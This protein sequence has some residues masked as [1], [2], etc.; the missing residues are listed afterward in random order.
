MGG[1][2][3]P[4]PILMNKAKEQEMFDISAKSTIKTNTKIDS[5][6]LEKRLREKRSNEYMDAI[7]KLDLGR[8]DQCKKQFNNCVEVIKSEFKD[9]PETH[10]LVGLL[11]K[12]YLGPPYDVH[13][14]DISG[15]I[16]IHYKKHE[17]IP[18]LMETARSL[19]LHGGYKFIE[20]YTDLLCAVKAD[21]TV[22]IVK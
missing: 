13:T 22:S 4:R 1:V 5:L 8:C 3:M 2:K 12:C 18:S 6:V 9:I 17:S 15:N 10:Q 16:M 21:G 14:V 11:A 19:A 20:V 7:G